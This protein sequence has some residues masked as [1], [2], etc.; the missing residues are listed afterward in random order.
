VRALFMTE[1]P[2]GTIAYG[3]AATAGATQRTRDAVLQVGGL[4]DDLGLGGV[5]RARVV[6]PRPNSPQQA[7]DL[8]R[9]RVVIREPN[10]DKQATGGTATISPSVRGAGSR[11]SRRIKPVGHVSGLAPWNHD[12]SHVIAGRFDGPPTEANAMTLERRANQKHM[13]AFEDDV[14]RRA[15]AGETLEYFVSPLYD[16]RMSPPSMVLMTAFGHREGPKARV[17]SNPARG[18]R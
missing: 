11:F 13:K 3:A 2:F 9:P 17:I 16:D 18:R 8:T 1:H 15:R 6:R 10:A 12:R 14:A 7:L 5:T 4:V